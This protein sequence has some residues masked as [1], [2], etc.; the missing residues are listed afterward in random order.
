MTVSNW[1]D[2]NR[3]LSSEA[4]SEPGKWDTAR[5]EYQR[6]IQDAWN[7]TTVEK[8]VVMTSAQVGKTEILNNCL[9][10]IIDRDPGP[11]LFLQPSVEMAETW[12][13]DRFDP[14]I[15]DT[16][17][18]KEKVSDNK[19]RDSGNTI[20]HKKF[21]GGHITVVGTNAPS[22]LASRPCRFILADEC[23]RY[24]TSSGGEG[25]PL[26]L[27]IKRTNNFWNRKIMLVSTPTIK[28]FSRIEQAFMESDQRYFFVPC[29]H[30]KEM[31]ILR[32]GNVIWDKGDEKNPRMKC[33]NCSGEF[34]DGLKNR[35]VSLGE[36][37]ATAPF[38]KTAGFHLN[39]LYSPWRKLSEIVM[40]FLESKPYPDR[41][42]VWVNTSLGETWDGGGES[43]SEHELMERQE[44]Y[45]AQVPARGL[46]LTAGVDTQQDRL[47]CEI[48]AWGAG[49]E[50][51]SIDYTV[52]YGDPDIPEGQPG[53][54]WTLLTDHLR[55]TWKHE[56]GV[57]LQVQ[58]TCVDSGGSNTQSVYNYVK[59]H[60]GSRVF[61][62]KGQS[63]E[64][65]PIVGSPLR[66]KTGKVQRSVAL[67]IIGVDQAKSVIMR[68]LKINEPGAG[69]CHFPHDRDADYFRQLT[70]ETMRTKFVKGFPKREWH[71]EDKRRNE[72][73]DCRVYAFGAFVLI[74]PQMDKVAY[75][76][77]Q[78]KQFIEA[79]HSPQ[80][81]EK[82]DPTEITTKENKPVLVQNKNQ[83]PVRPQRR[84]GG[85]VN[86][87]RNL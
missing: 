14:M 3:I 64:N 70:S 72:A 79:N 41:L 54:P 19:S 71:K 15:R 34:G 12:S 37:R 36:W 23:D 11:T 38:K 53:S 43:I 80:S 52:L 29:P 35:A 13:K 51:W 87:W 4:S 82:S 77:K 6:G 45:P 86:S 16:N 44:K 9:G 59:R 31:H 17:C 63:G 1:A 30:C 84:I 33:P 73:L 32:W 85:F 48:V 22:Q 62:I 74:S 8:V 26:T 65:L 49:E 50:S 28:G 27:A 5:A 66:K 18:L 56:T 75:R 42:Q 55:R 46:Y 10:Y 39:E 25:D 57:E 2:T 7:E 69:Y 40:D 60:K 83:K 20:H 76:L 67:F 47:E 78:S 81:D 68:R 61:A 58:S 21:P 24:P